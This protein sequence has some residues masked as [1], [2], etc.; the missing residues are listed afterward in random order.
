MP[1]HDLDWHRQDMKDELEEF[2]D[3]KGFVHRWS[4]I[5]DVVYTY[6]RG[7]WSGH[8]EL[9][10]P[11]S[12]KKFLWG[13]LYMFPKYTFR[14]LLFYIAGKKLGA[15]QKVTEVRNPKKLHKLDD[16]AERNGINV[17]EFRDYISRKLRYWPLLK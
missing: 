9:C 16:I 8:K 3:A 5:S 4:E 1:K 12:R 2:A 10:F 17:K 6:T 11:L 15:K 13:L 14:W 7:R